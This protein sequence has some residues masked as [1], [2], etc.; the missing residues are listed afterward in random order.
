MNREYKAIEKI[1]IKSQLF[2]KVDNTKKTVDRLH[3]KNNR[4]LK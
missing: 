2:E 4:K 1:L 3:N